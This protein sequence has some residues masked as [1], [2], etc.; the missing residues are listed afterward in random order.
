MVLGATVSFDTNNDIK[1]T[2]TNSAQKF[3]NPNML[4][5]L[6]ALRHRSAMR[7]AFKGRDETSL[8]PILR[9]VIKYI[10]HPRYIKLTSDVAMLLLDLYSEQTMDSPEIDDLLNQLHRKVRHCS[11]LAQAAYSTQGMLELLVSGA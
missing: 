7:T 1:T 9:W 6:T 10:G 11:E 2:R 4:T 8:Q 3:Y 5:L